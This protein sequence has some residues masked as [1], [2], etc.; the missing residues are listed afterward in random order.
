MIDPRS[1]VI[2]ALNGLEWEPFNGGMVADFIIDDIAGLERFVTL[3]LALRP[4]IVDLDCG[5]AIAFDGAD[6]DRLVTLG[7][8]FS[9]ASSPVERLVANRSN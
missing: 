5:Y 4:A 6:C 2:A 9:I 8:R 1:E 7:V 3:D